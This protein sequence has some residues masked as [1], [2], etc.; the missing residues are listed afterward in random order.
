MSFVALCAG[1]LVII[2]IDS[3]KLTFTV[4]RGSRSPLLNGLATK[5]HDFF[6][7]H[8]IAIKMNY[9]PRKLNQIVDDV[10]RFWTRTT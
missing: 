7:E 1:A 3:R 10:C 6:T 5:L 4:G 9:I 2:Q 8:S